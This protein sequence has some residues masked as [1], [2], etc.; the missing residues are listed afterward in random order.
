MRRYDE[1]FALI[2]EGIIKSQEYGDEDAADE[3]TE[4]K[5][6]AKKKLEELKNEDY[7]DW[8]KDWLLANRDE[9]TES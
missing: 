7:P 9:T 2:E 5:T 8:Y 6:I 3:F 1:A 4:A